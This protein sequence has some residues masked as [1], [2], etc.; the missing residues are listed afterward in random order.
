MQ[1]DG[2]GGIGK[3]AARKAMVAG[4]SFTPF[5]NLESVKPVSIPPSPCDMTAARSWATPS[6]VSADELL[7]YLQGVVGRLRFEGAAALA[8]DGLTSTLLGDA[9]PFEYS[10]ASPSNDILEIAK[11]PNTGKPGTWYVNPGSGQ[12]RLYGDGGRPAVDID[13]DHDHGQGIPH[14]HN[15]VID[16]LHGK[17]RRGPGVPI[18]ILP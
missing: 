6:D 13:F 8:G 7:S 14:A 11:T 3:R 16:P 1:S 15:W 10:E 18:S 12:M 17:L 9:Q 2:S 5:S 4:P